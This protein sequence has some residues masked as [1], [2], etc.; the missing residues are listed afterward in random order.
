MSDDK[1]NSVKSVSLSDTKTNAT[2]SME[3]L[4]PSENG[5]HIC[6]CINDKWCFKHAGLSANNVYDDNDCLCFRCLDCCTWCLE[7]KQKKVTCL[8]KEKTICFMCCFSITFH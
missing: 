3:A 7:F 1:A 4:I 6:C 2:N 8:C 5:K